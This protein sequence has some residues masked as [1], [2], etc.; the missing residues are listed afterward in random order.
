MTWRD[1]QDRTGS[2]QATELSSESGDFWF[3]NA[4]S[5]ELIVKVIDACTSTGNYWVFWRALSNVEMDLV[6]RNTDDPPDAH[7]PQSAWAT[8][9]TVIW[10]STRSSAAT[11]PDPPRNPSTPASISPRRGSRTS[12]S[13]SNPSLIDPCVPDGD[14]TICLQGGRFRVQGIWSDFAGGSGNA[15]LIKKNES[16]GYAWFFN[17]NNYEMLFKLVDACSYN[18]NTWVSIAGL[19]NVAAS[20]DDPGHLDRNRLP[21]GECVGRRF[22]DQSRHRD[23]SR[24]LRTFAFLV[25]HTASVRTEGDGMT[26]VGVARRAVA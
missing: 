21:A 8:T 12:S 25:A 20:A 1:F 18:G 9:P 16:S 3:F 24:L 10:T 6:I 13:S 5:N 2:G 22:P 26:P 17:S 4:Q 7:L 19:T 15:H 14:R 11:A 23:Q